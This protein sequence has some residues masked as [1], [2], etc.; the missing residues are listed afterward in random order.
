M[1]D[2]KEAYFNETK[3]QNPLLVAH[4][5][6]NLAMIPQVQAVLKRLDQRLIYRAQMFA[7]AMFL[8]YT[9]VFAY[10]V[11]DVTIL[12][13]K[14]IQE[15][16]ELFVF[17]ALFD[18]TIILFYFLQMVNY[19]AQCN[20]MDHQF[21]IYFVRLRDECIKLKLETQ[22]YGFYQSV[23]D[24]DKFVINDESVESTFL[25]VVNLENG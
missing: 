4:N 12:G 20:A 3:T 8:M 15:G 17:Y 10:I 13:S 11:V 9:L 23:E 25:F 7:G 14:L 21:M 19:G 18:I 22:Q 16:G 5:P 6:K 2:L 24:P 1:L